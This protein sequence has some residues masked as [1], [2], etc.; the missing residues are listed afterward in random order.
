MSYSSLDL[1][2]LT[3]L[4]TVSVVAIILFAFVLQ[5]ST[6]HLALLAYT[7]AA[8]IFFAHLLVFKPKWLGLEGI[9]A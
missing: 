9:W 4:D 7:M 8:L 2:L 3:V 6:F 5:V 1:G